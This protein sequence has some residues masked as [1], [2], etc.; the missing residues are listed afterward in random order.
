MEVPIL[1]ATPPIPPADDPIPN[2][3][4]PTSQFGTENPPLPNPLHI[5]APFA[6]CGDNTVPIADWPD[7]EDDFGDF[8]S[9]WHWVIG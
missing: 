5:V 6:R 1:P 3:N 8:D 4:H 7:T 2:T 9:A